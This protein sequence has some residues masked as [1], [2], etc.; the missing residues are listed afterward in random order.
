MTPYVYPLSTTFNNTALDVLQFNFPHSTI[1]EDNQYYYVNSNAIDH[2][3]FDNSSISY[4]Y[5]KQNLFMI[6]GTNTV[7]TV[8]GHHYKT[9]IMLQQQS[10]IAGPNSGSRTKTQ[11]N[12]P[13]ISVPFPSEFFI[14]TLLLLPVFIKKTRKHNIDLQ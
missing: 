13:P 3:T 14:V 12:E 5:D 7:T 1:T 11:D 9:S 8:F 10:K 4:T 6:S 2:Y